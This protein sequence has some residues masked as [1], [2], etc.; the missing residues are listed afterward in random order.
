M[1]DETKEVINDLIV[2]L[3]TCKGKF[4]EFGNIY[5]TSPLKCLADDWFKREF[6]LYNKM[7]I[8]IDRH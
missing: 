4:E 8:S 5:E 3:I 2:A 7:K 1:S 6:K